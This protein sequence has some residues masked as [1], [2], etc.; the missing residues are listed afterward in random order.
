MYTHLAYNRPVRWS[1]NDIDI[2]VDDLG[3]DDPVVP[4]RITTPAGVLE[5]VAEPAQ[6]G[7]RL[8]L[9][10]LHMHGVDVGPRQFGLANLRALA[11]AV[12]ER[13]DLDEIVI[14]GAVRTSGAN[15]GHRPGE[16]RFTRKAQVGTAG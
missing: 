12:M 7:R 11:Q 5:V 2:E 3:T 10:R 14:R 15:P 6:E 13:M 4:A 9:E 1:G 16:R 8:V